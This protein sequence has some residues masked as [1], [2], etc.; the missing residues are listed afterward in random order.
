MLTTFRTR[1]LIL[2]T[3]LWCQPLV[4]ATDIA[5]NNSELPSGLDPANAQAT[6]WAQGLSSYDSG[7]YDEAI[8][9]FSK[10]LVANPAQGHV[11]YNLG[12]SL[13]RAQRTGEALAAYYAARRYLPRDPDLKANI[14]YVETFTTDKLKS[15]FP[16]APWQQAFFW[17]PQITLTESAYLTAG[18]AGIAILI[19]AL[20][21]FL[22]NIK[23]ATLVINAGLSAVSAAL[24]IGTVIKGQNFSLWGAVTSEQVAIHADKNQEAAVVF[25]LRKGAPVSLQERDGNWTMIKISDGKK[26]WVE[27]DNVR[28]Y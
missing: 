9:N 2:S 22:P 15:Q 5:S 3:I 24:A 27:N 21:L 16:Q 4:A 7:A 23:K 28:F 11:L 14:A 18:V 13:Y 6:L 17:L 8:T 25:E 1:L 12:N 20:G 10:M 26:G 19:F